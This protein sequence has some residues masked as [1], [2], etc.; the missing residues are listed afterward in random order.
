MSS[1]LVEMLRRDGCRVEILRRDARKD[2]SSGCLLS[3]P[4]LFSCS[5]IYV[6][7]NINRVSFAVSRC[8]DR[9]SYQLICLM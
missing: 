5:K 4:I 3:C 6:L 9:L 1:I 2:A 7:W 8:R